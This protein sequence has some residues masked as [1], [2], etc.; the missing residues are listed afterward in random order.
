MNTKINAI[1]LKYVTIIP[2]PSNCKLSTIE[3]LYYVCDINNKEKT[4][5]LIDEVLEN[6]R[7]LAYYNTTCKQFANFI[8]ENYPVYSKAKIPIGYHKGFQY[9][10]FIKNPKCQPSIYQREIK[11]KV[12]KFK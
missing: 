9:H 4:I 8:I 12:K 10:L 11:E 1:Y 5:K 7:I 3:N 6:C 2:S